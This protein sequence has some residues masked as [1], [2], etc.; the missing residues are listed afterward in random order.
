MAYY[1]FL[2]EV[3]DAVREAGPDLS[4][5]L[6][7]P[8]YQGVR[9]RATQRID[10]AL[11]DGFAPANV[12]DQR[13]ALLELLSVP[14][15]R[16]LAASFADKILINRYAAAEARVVHDHLV[17]DPDP[18]AIDQ[19]LAALGIPA[20]RLEAAGDG[21]WRLHITAYIRAAPQDQAWRLILRPVAAGHVEL[22][23]NEM[24]RL[25]Q[26]ALQ[27]R[28]T[29]ELES[30]RARPMPEEIKNALAPL[31]AHLEPRV[32]EAR[33]TWNTGDFGPVQPDLFP[34][35]IKEVFEALKRSENVPH[36]GRFAFATF[37]HTVGWNSEQIL[38]YLST[39]PNFSREKSRYQ[40]E[41]ITGEKSVQAYTPPG[42]AT[43]Q[44][45]GTCPLDK[46]DGLCF[47]IKHPLNYYRAQLRFK[48]KD[49]P[50]GVTPTTPSS[51]ENTETTE[52]PVVRQ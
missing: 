30:E 16:M 14:L 44:T 42:C 5:V 48:G 15:A 29:T 49:A 40:I 2:P 36:H 11:A 13:S 8:L 4:A 26:E 47:K 31:I 43:M 45:N 38:D 7:S 46:R 25:V 27:R 24:A 19:A 32:E 20:E 34:P 9:D 33:L 39:T 3:R 35:C 12:W 17:R 22:D 41:H 50:V 51:T 10:G 1:P 52:K 18:E 23:R 21:V 37:L 6:T 28:I